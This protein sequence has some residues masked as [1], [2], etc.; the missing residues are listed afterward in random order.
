M[1]GG[2]IIIFMPLFALL[3]GMLFDR[4]RFVVNRVLRFIHLRLAHFGR[5]IHGLV[6]VLAQ[7]F[8]LFAR[9]GAHAGKRR[10]QSKA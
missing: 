4:F 9:G 10:P 3:M 8:I 5:L 6:A 1:L 7:G 2:V